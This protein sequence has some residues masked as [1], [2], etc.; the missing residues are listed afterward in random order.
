VRFVLRVPA[1]NDRGPQYMDQVLAA[2]HQA[3]PRRLP[4][5][6]EVCQIDCQVTLSCR[7]PDELRTVIASQLYAQYPE[8]DIRLIPDEARVPDP[9]RQ[10][11]TRELH[12]HHGIFPIRRYV[13]FEDALNRVSADPLTALFMALGEARRPASLD[14][15]ITLTIAPASGAWRRRGERCLRRLSGPFFRR[16]H[17]LARLYSS[18]AL[19]HRLCLRVAAWCLGRLERSPGE[20]SSG[21]TTSTGRQHDR[22]EE[23]QAAADKLGRLLFQV[24]LRLEVTGKTED[25]EAARRKL[26]EMTGAFGQFSL[27]RLASFRKTRSR[28]GHGASFLLSTEELAT[29]WHLPTLTV[30][31]PTMKT[32]ETRELPPPAELPGRARDPDLAI[33]GVTAFRDRRERLVSMN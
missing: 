6:L 17:H 3:N 4:I 28:F 1:G 19:S 14:A 21:L 27:P 18:W 31:A 5:H 20:H 22:E 8:C 30:R 11:W 24:H 32:V 23:L 33:V 12:L 9:S 7:F 2:V 26:D 25:A 15:R 29:I 10:T 13:Q 16:H